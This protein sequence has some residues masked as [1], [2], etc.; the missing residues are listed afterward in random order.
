MSLSRPP[1]LSSTSLSM[2]ST[3]TRGDDVAYQERQGGSGDELDQDW[4]YIGGRR[5]ER[6]RSSSSPPSD[7]SYPTITTIPNT[8]MKI[9]PTIQPGTGDRRRVVEPH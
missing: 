2:V 7:T 8:S 1:S 3:T 9:Y 5:G 4:G 6:G